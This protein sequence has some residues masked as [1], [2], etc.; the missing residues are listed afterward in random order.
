MIFDLLPAVGILV[1]GVLY[2]RAVVIRRRSVVPWR[3]AS[4]YLGLMA[5]TLAIYGRV[6]HLSEVTFSGHMIQHVILMSVAAPLVVVGDAGRLLRVGSPRS[7]VRAVSLVPAGVRSGL[8]N[9]L[10][11][12]AAFI[13]AL[14]AWH[15]PALYEAAL[16]HQAL[17]AL[18]HASFFGTSLLLWTTAFGRRRSS[19]PV[20]LLVVFVTSLAAAALGAIIVFAGSVLYPTHAV[21]AAPLGIDA[22]V[23]QQLAGA[24]MWIPPG[25]VSLLAMVVLAA[26]MLV[27]GRPKPAPAGSER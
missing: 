11:C 4:F 15:L 24:I 18:E 19:E 21:I 5:V 8:R 13:V 22:L 16:L 9:P 1:A 20:A 23:D 25:V 17:H 3:I 2:L 12:G 10:V 27:S 7:L 26:R 14:W 6:G